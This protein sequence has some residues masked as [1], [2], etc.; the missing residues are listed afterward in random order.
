MGLGRVVQAGAAMKIV[1]QIDLT[2]LR[3]VLVLLETAWWQFRTYRI[4]PF[5]PYAADKAIRLAELERPTR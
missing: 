3:P 1:I 5:S 4:S 2:K